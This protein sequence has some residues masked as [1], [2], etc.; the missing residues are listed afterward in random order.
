MSPVCPLLH[1]HTLKASFDS[2]LSKAGFKVAHIDANQYYGGNEAS[3]TLDELVQ[4]TD[5]R[6]AIAIDGA[7][8]EYHTNQRKR[9]IAMSR[10]QTL[11]PQS[12]QYAVSLVPSIVPSIGPHI[13]SLIASG[14]SRYGQFKLLEKVAVYDRPGY[15]QSVP[16]SKEDVFKSKALSLVDKRRLMR[17]LLFAAGDF[18][19]KKEVEGKE[20]MPFLQYLKEVFSLNDKAA[21]AIAYALAF[22]NSAEGAW[23]VTP[24]YSPCFD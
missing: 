20:E 6:D 5:T 17:F 3:L 10:S 1:T 22:C 23:Y 19:G 24:T 21:S 4:W 13:D 14:V 2:A 11:P 16:G 15:V 7:S 12:R 18:E 9:Y 8:S